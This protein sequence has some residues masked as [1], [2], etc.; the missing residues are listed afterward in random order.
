MKCNSEGL[1][2]LA[3]IPAV[4]TRGYRSPPHNISLDMQMFFQTYKIL[5]YTASNDISKHVY[6]PYDSN[7]KAIFKNFKINWWEQKSVRLWLIF[8]KSIWNILNETSIGIWYISET[9]T[10]LYYIHQQE[11]HTKKKSSKERKGRRGKRI[12]IN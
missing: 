10:R 8:L 5:Q 1:P 12:Y 2:Y 4:R 7:R 9:D 6:L 3:A 11:F